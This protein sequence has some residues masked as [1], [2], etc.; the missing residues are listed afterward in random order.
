[1]ANGTKDIWLK[2]LIGL[3]ITL[4]SGVYVLKLDKGMFKQHEKYQDVQYK[5][6]KSSLVRIEQKI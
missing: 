6:I 3:L 4:I 5:E 1:M 2:L